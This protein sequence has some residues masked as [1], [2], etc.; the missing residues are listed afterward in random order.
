MLQGAGRKLLIC[1]K[2]LVVL[3]FQRVVLAVWQDS[4]TFHFLMTWEQSCCL[5]ITHI[6]VV[7]LCSVR[8]GL[9]GLRGHQRTLH[10]DH[11]PVLRHENGRLGAAHAQ[12]L[13]GRAA[14]Q[15]HHRLH[16]GQGWPDTPAHRLQASHRPALALTGAREIWHPTKWCT[17]LSLAATAEWYEWDTACFAKASKRADITGSR[18]RWRVMKLSIACSGCDIFVA[19]FAAPVAIALHLP[20]LI[21]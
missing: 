14:A 10:A 11:L 1:C 2:V 8:A 16:R 5:K 13:A 6:Q 3:L 17:R 9:F 18:C 19:N 12:R 4:A 20:H 15:A 7:G 21:C